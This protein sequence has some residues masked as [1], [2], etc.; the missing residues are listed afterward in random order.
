MS[1]SYRRPY[2][3]ITG[4][5]S[6]KKDKQLAARG[7]RRKQNQWL[8]TL[9]DFNE[10]GLVPHRL[11]CRYNDVWSWSRDGHQ[12]LRVPG[13]RDWDLYMRVQ[14]GLFRDQWEEKWLRESYS[15]WPPE[16]YADVTRK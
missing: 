13:R 10:N 2:Q 7:V 1:R 3:A 5:P 6:A 4:S 11:D 14:Q 9:E 8:K 16:F 12:C 15:V